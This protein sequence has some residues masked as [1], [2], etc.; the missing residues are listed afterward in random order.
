MHENTFDDT[1]L[2][3]DLGHFHESCV[4]ISAILLDDSLHPVTLIVDVLLVVDL[5]PEFDLRT[6]YRN[7]DDAHL[8]IF[9]KHLNHLAAEEIHWAEIVALTADRRYC[10][11]PLTHLSAKI[12]HVNCRYKLKARIVEI[13]VLFCRP[14]SSLHVGLADAQIDMEVRIRLLCKCRDAC[15]YR[16]QCQ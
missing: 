15:S 4:W 9:R 2:L 3:S 1:V 13:L 7:V 11:V 14:C 12:R 10:S 16:D 6:C 5:V 8:D